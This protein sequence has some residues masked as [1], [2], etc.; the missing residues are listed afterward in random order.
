MK[1]H[2]KVDIRW[3]DED[4]VFV[5][6]VPELDGVMTHGKN[7]AE[8]ARMAEEAIDLHLESLEA[9]DD[10]IPEPL[11]LKGLKRKST[12]TSSKKLR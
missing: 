1:P 5:A 3:D 12:R 2:F 9:H 4:K 11:S 8:A 10:P 6:R 7:V